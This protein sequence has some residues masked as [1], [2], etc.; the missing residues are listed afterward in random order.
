MNKDLIE[1]PRFNFF[2]GDEVLLKGK[3]VGFDVDENKC[4][5]N[6]VRL[7]Y[8]QTLN[9]PNNNIYITDDIV[10]KSKIKVVV[11]QFVAD[12]YE[13]NKDSF[14][15]NVWDWIAFR[16][17]A[18]KSENREF[19]NWINNTRENPIQTLV[20]MHNFGYEVEK[21]KRYLVK[22]KGVHFTNYLISGNRKD[23]WFFHSAYEPEHQIIAHTRK[24][25]EE[26]GFGWVFDCPGIEIEEVE[27]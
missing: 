11:P 22:V 6:V 16:D 24:E 27:E 9:V 8:G 21:E 13:E 1:T 14:E 4:V 12:W 5:E 2:I 26:A 10:D 20:N 15:F 7:E 19:N 23:I 25:L 3:I 18:K 17:E